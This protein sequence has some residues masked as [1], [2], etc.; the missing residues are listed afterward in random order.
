MHWFFC[1]FSLSPQHL[2]PS[3]ISRLFSFFYL[4]S[5]FLY[6]ISPL[7]PS[8]NSIS[9][10]FRYFTSLS[11][12]SDLSSFA[13][14]TISHSAL[15]HTSLH[16]HQSPSSLLFQL[17]FPLSSPHTLSHLFTFTS[18]IHTYLSLYISLTSLFSFHDIPLFHLPI[19]PHR[20]RPLTS[21][22]SHITSHTPLARSPIP[23]YLYITSHL[24]HIYPLVHLSFI[25]IFIYTSL[26][27]WGLWECFCVAAV[28]EYR[29]LAFEY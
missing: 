5:L 21:L 14:I 2:H 22:L 23:I 27:S 7:S 29:V 9:N 20:L 10:T 16:I 3:P 17:P 28:V 6:H 13:V 18:H 19:S 26:A 4:I 12:P 8:P 15:S 24:L 1:K 11:P 25:L